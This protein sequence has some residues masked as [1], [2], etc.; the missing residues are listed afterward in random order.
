AASGPR[1]QAGARHG[2]APAAG[3]RPPG[4]TCSGKAKSRNRRDRRLIK[5]VVDAE[6]DRLLGAAVLANDGEFDLKSAGAPYQAH[7]I[8][9]SGSRSC[10]I[11]NKTSECQPAPLSGPLRRFWL[12]RRHWSPAPIRASAR[13]PRSLS[14]KPA[15]MSWLIT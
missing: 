4:S 14:G 7:S 12:A 9:V 8:E 11:L 6:T 13:R 1:V 3:P 15:P 2:E 10:V 5:V